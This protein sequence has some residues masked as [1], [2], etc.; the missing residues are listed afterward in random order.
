M[1]HLGMSC[2]LMSHIGQTSKCLFYALKKFDFHLELNTWHR[3]CVGIVWS[4]H[5]LPGWIII[6][7]V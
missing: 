7:K 6:E 2:L 4:L 3:I 1:Q 5:H